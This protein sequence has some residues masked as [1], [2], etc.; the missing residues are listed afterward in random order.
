MDTREWRNVEKRPTLTFFFRALPSLYLS[1]IVC[2]F[3]IYVFS[4]VFWS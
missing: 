3:H 1:N 2:F 4:N